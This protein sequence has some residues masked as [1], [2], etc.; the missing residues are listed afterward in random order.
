VGHAYS[1][2]TLV[3]EQDMA[4]ERA[5]WAAMRALEESAQLSDRMAATFRERRHAALAARMAERGQAARR[6]AAQLR[7]LLAS[8]EVPKMTETVDG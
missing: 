2:E 8:D 3:A 4:H 1:A 5:L 7:K 6:H